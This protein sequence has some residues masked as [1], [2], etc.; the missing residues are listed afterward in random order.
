MMASRMEKRDDQVELP[1]K[2]KGASSCIKEVHRIRVQDK[3]KAR[4]VRIQ[5]SLR[6]SPS[7]HPDKQELQVR[8]G[9]ELLCQQG[10]YF[11]DVSFG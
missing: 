3:L 10:H 8:G 6:L 5:G 4:P 2:Q 11:G 7:P 9:R 1:V